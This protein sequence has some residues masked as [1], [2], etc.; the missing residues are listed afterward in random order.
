M[1]FTG[2]TFSKKGDKAIEDGPAVELLKDAG[3]IPL[4]VT[5]TPEF[6]LGIHTV[7]VIYGNTKNPY[8]TRISPGASSGGE[9]RARVTKKYLPLSKTVV[10]LIIFVF[11]LNNFVSSGLSFLICFLPK[12]CITIT[13]KRKSTNLTVPVHL[14][15]RFI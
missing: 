15:L 7:N 10:L 9:V 13:M 8:D 5:N 12:Q 4:C 2:G 6:C 11:D 14:V 1:S 3:A